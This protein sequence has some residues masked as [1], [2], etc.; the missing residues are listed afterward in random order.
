MAER[1]EYYVL[2]YICSN[3]KTRYN[4]EIPFGTEALIFLNCPNCGNNT[5]KP[6]A[7]PSEYSVHGFTIK[8]EQIVPK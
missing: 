4:I 2:P 7:Q 1:I 6:N 3:C 8:N 5:C